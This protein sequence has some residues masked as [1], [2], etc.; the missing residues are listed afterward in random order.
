MGPDRIV[1][2]GFSQGACVACDYLARNPRPL[3]ALVVLCGGLI[4]AGEVELAEPA[5]GS[6]A[7]LPVLITATEEDAWVPVE[8]VR[9]S[10]AALE[11]AGARVD[12]RIYSP[13]EHEVHAEEVTALAE[14]V[15]AVGV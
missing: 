4:G 6:L 14:L 2:G 13:G 11:R 9:L 12:L 1:L 5:A 3:G 7:G 8:R 15:G 10:G